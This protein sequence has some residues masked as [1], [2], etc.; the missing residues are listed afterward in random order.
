MKL[1]SVT[2]RMQTETLFV[3]TYLI[4]YLILTTSTLSVFVKLCYPSDTIFFSVL[5][6]IEVLR[7]SGPLM[8]G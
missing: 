6:D 8:Y 3:L 7:K 1:V 2:V 4:V 5:Y